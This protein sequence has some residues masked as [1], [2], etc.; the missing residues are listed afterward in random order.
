MVDAIS[1]GR[2]RSRPS[3]QAIGST[4]RAKASRS[5]SALLVVAALGSGSA[6]Q[7]VDL[8]GHWRVEIPG[9]S[10]PQIADIVQVGDAVTVTL[11]VSGFSVDFSGTITGAQVSLDAD[12]ADV[13]CPTA[14]SLRIL[15][16][17]NVLDGRL[18]AFSPDV[19][20]PP[21]VARML[22]TRCSCFDGNTN[23]G[24]GCDATC[25]AEPCFTCAGDPS[26]CTPS[27][28]GA[29]CDD[30][31][32]C[33]TGTT[34]SAGACGGG[35]SVPACIDLGGRWFQRE[36]TDLI[37]VVTDTTDVEQ[38]DGI[39]VFRSPAG[40]QPGRV[41][42]IDVTTGAMDLR[43]PPT[44]FFCVA[45]STFTGTA[46][47]DGR[48]WTGGGTGGVDT[49]R[50][51]LPTSF[52]E[53][54]WRCGGG[55]LDAGE[56]CDDG[57]RNPGDGCDDACAVDPC[58]GC[59]GEPSTCT[60]TV[61]AACDD[62]NACT[63]GDTCGPQG[64][65][66]GTAVACGRC[67]AC[68]PVGGCVAAP[69]TDCQLATRPETALLHIGDRSPDSRD[70][71]RWRWSGGAEL[72]LAELGDPTRDTDV[73]LC[74]F[75]ESASTPA[76]AFRATAPAGGT[77]GLRPCWQSG[78]GGFQYRNPADGGDGLTAVALRAD[79]R[80]KLKG[81]GVALS[82]RSHGLPAPPLA[83]PLRV[84]LQLDGAACLETRHDATSVQRNLTGT[85][86]SR[87]AP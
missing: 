50:G 16:G 28:D 43:V 71:M 77:C 64:C 52:T 60:P 72:A 47:P 32:D 13:P 58:F 45:D 24:D 31:R 53:E 4:A 23:D 20:N 65:I 48:T 19:C 41:G 56:A 15:P 30:R 81:R 37:G 57:N 42:T 14:G 1:T 40:G 2:S 21:G 11:D 7:A 9:A 26:V 62:G 84:Q 38:R 78:A 79:G 17:D 49:L 74:V 12:P 35:A 18:L 61:G 33:T 75:D 34:C 6:A 85:F 68:D 87:G 22:A 51:C 59:T 3:R 80:A 5:L 83:L 46:A 54:A 70:V 10:S 76:L 39:L 69:R 67:T 36:D 86:K 44:G 82:S 29:A 66:P 73:S 27:A 55:T 63:T 25:Q 8:T